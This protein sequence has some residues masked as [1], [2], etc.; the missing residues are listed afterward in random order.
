MAN[1]RPF[2]LPEDVG[3]QRKRPAIYAVRAAA[4]TLRSFITGAT[5]TSAA[6]KMFGDDPITGYVLRAATAPAELTVVGWAQEI[7]RVAIFDLVQS[8]TSLSAG[9]EV[10]SRGLQLNLV[11]RSSNLCFDGGRASRVT[12]A[13]TSKKPPRRKAA[14]SAAMGPSN[15]TNSRVSARRKHRPCGHRNQRAP[16]C[17]SRRPSS[18][19]MRR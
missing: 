8:I 4:A 5:P 9:A 6:K 10:I 7:G 17:S 12:V 2:A 19:S 18:V 1:G 16:C 15:P 11:R 3:L 13:A 14:F